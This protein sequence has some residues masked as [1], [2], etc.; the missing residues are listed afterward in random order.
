M[1][2]TSPFGSG[3]PFTGYQW[4]ACPYWYLVTHHRVVIYV[5]VNLCSIFHLN[6]YN[7]EGRTLS[8]YQ[9]EPLHTAG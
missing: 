2:T 3:K 5:W 9:L 7:I 4:V 1:M 6:Y 8:K